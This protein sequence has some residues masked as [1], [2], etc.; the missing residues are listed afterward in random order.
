M[1]EVNLQEIIDRHNADPRFL[2]EMMHDV[3]DAYNYLPRNVLE[4]LCKRLDV[5]LSRAYSLATFYS[6]FSLKPKAKYPIKVCIGTAC[7]VWG[8]SRIIEKL[9][10]ELNI[11]NW[12]TTKD[13]KFSLGE[14]LCPGC[15]GLA[16]VVTV[17]EDIHGRV[18]LTS[19][20]KILKKYKRTD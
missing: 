14:V 18:K 13:L 16:P 17:G 8:A 10:N 5:P 15:C 12:E 6:A 2:V 1:K 20:P 7:Y 19:I 11:K 4:E 9:E 3:Q